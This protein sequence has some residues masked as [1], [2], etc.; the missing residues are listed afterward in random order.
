MLVIIGVLIYAIANTGT[1]TA[2]TTPGTTTGAGPT[3]AGTQNPS[4]STT[5]LPNPK[6]PAAPATNR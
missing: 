1:Q 6:A 4:Q 2:S 5:T 3:A